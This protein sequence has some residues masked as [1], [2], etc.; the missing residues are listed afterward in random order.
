[1]TNVSLALYATVSI[2]ISTRFMFRRCVKYPALA[3]LNHAG[4]RNVQQT[5]FQLLHRKYFMWQ[6]KKH[7]IVDLRRSMNQEYYCF[8]KSVQN[9]FNSIT[10]KNKRYYKLIASITPPRELSTVKMREIEY[11]RRS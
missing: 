1:M 2:F 3:Q 9:F 6:K 7:F 5:N 8:D 11:G 10:V 4:H